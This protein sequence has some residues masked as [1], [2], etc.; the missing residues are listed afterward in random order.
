MPIPL[1]PKAI[2]EKSTDS[3]TANCKVNP[4]MCLWQC[5]I[6]GVVFASL[7]T[8]VSFLIDHRAPDVNSIFT[9]LSI[10]VPTLFLL[11]A[12]DLEYSD[13]LARVAGWSLG[14]KMFS[15]LAN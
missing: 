7:F 12:L 11:K 15:A 6:D 9:F 13:Q 14:S 3:N 5:C 4:G 10:W 1:S 8:A 2:L